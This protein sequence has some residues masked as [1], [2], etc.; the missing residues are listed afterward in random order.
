MQRLNIEPWMLYVLPLLL[1]T[2]LLLV[3][4]STKA[5]AWVAGATLLLASIGPHVTWT[6]RVYQTWVLPLQ[7]NRSALFFMCCGLLLIG[8]LFHAR[9]LRG[10]RFPL[11]ASMLLLIGLYAGLLRIVHDDITTSIT[12]IAG[13]LLSVGAIGY[14]AVAT[15][16]KYDGMIN[17]VRSIALAGL[18]WTGM[19]AVQF[20]LN[21]SLIVIPRPPRFLGLGNNPQSTAIMLGPMA[22][23]MLWLA[24]NDPWRVLKPMWYA[25]VG[26]FALLIIWSGSRTGAGMFMLG[27]VM[28]TYSRLGKVV[29]LLPVAG[30]VLFLLL[31]VLQAMGMEITSR[32]TSTENTR[33]EVWGRLINSALSN[34]I[35][36]EGQNEEVGSENSYLFGFA[37]YGIGM[38]IIM[39][40]YAGLIGWVSLKLLR[41]KKILPDHYA[42]L[43][44]ICHGYFAAY[45]FGS[46]FEGYFLARVASNL[47][48]ML[49]FAGLAS[50][51]LWVA[52]SIR[53]GDPSFEQG[54]YLEYPAADFAPDS[55]AALDWGE[56]DGAAAGTSSWEEDY[57]GSEY[58][59][60]RAT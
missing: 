7:L 30:L 28:V 2:A 39:L 27:A 26:L 47:V 59:G 17:L 6:K 22:T 58:E 48:F 40:S 24:I 31:D 11:L 54:A 37:A 44:D 52:R 15:S 49:L 45:L 16:E 50:R 8:V 25:S 4:K 21:R 29:F 14:A 23:T 57:H 20:V 42:R 60:A 34:P 5:L 46:I 9:R 18:V 53:N 13:T 41:A 35:I 12:S 38:L 56:Q 1:G 32:V 51:L 33:D 55:T 43:V 36:G 10:V 19:V 3:G